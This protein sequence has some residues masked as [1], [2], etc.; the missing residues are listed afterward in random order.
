MKIPNSYDEFIQF[1]LGDSKVKGLPSQSGG[2]VN[3]D[4]NDD[5]YIFHNDDDDDSDPDRTDD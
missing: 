2:G 3:N 4:D 1:S 5:T